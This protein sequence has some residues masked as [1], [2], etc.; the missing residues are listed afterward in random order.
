MN[1]LKHQLKQTT[2][3]GNPLR[4]G[5]RASLIAMRWYQAIYAVNCAVLDPRP[6]YPSFSESAV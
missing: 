3:G 4:R 2:I 6:P 1:A 5:L